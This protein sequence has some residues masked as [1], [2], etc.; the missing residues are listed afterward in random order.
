MPLKHA[1]KE[2]PV[3]NGESPRGVFGHLRGEYACLLESAKG[4]RYS[5]IG[6]DPFSVVW[7]LNGV[8]QSIGKKN[9]FEIKKSATGQIYAGDSLD[10]LKQIF[11]RFE[12]KGETPVPFFGGAIG[13]FSYDYGCGFLGVKQKVYD[14]TGI[15]DYVF[16]FYDKIV[17]Y[18]HELKKKYFIALAETDFAVEKKLDEM[19]KDQEKTES[20]IRKGY[21]GEIR[22]NVTKDQYMA[23]I[24][25]IKKMLE[26]GETYQVNFSQRFSADCTLP[27]Y[28]VY[29]KLAKKNPAPFA[30]YLEFPQFS[31][32]SCSPELLLRKRGGR[33]ESWPIKGTIKRGKNAAEDEKLVKEL[34][35]SKKDR[36]ELSMITDLARNDLGRVSRTGSVTV[37]GFAEIEKCSHVMHTYSRVV[38]EIDEKKDLFDCL[39]ALFPGG[40]IT[41]CPKKRTVEIIDKLEDYMRGVYTGSAGFIS[42]SGECDLNILIRTML[43]KDGKVYFHSG[44]GIVY[45]SVAEKE[46]NETIDKAKALISSIKK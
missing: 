26:R 38:S 28:E 21:V 1:F 42:F 9:F 16:C 22:S 18:D 11:K 19:E 34:L 27:P 41:G 6:Y 25:E 20:L 2:M 31:V 10:A 17:A 13:F 23:K 39:K 35:C 24:C 45:D 30:C 15:P 40:S 7:S 5:Y 32:V 33:L 44:G 4:G 8:A 3:N 37:E 46:Y 36:A 12:L 43:F 14:D 29:K